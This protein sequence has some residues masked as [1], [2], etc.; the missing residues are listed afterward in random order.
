MSTHRPLFPILRSLS[1]GQLST[2]EDRPTLD[3]SVDLLRLFL[4]PSV[5]RVEMSFSPGVL[6]VSPVKKYAPFVTHLSLLSE[7][8]DYQ[9]DIGE[10]PAYEMWKTTLMRNLSA[11]EHLLSLAI[12]SLL[13]DS[14][15]SVLLGGIAS[16][17]SLTV[18]Y[19]CRG[20]SH[21]LLFGPESFPSL[22]CLLL[23]NVPAGEAISIIDQPELGRR[24]RVLNIS[25]RVA[26][27]SDVKEHLATILE[28]I[29]ERLPLVTKITLRPCIC[30]VAEYTSY[31]TTPGGRK[32]RRAPPMRFSNELVRQLMGL[33]SSLQYLEVACVPVAPRFL[34]EFAVAYPALRFLSLALDLGQSE[35]LDQP[36]VAVKAKGPLHIEA[37]SYY[38]PKSCGRSLVDTRQAAF[39]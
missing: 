30:E 22:T 27:L 38:P 4:S 16:L 28:R 3:P 5:T 1:L 23:E 20:V 2:G 37:Y 36:T 7:C 12:P 10:E 31:W 25:L 15:A 13:L 6:D 19:G 14:P 9:P 24:L 18:R 39:R 26:W 34:R 8:L 29:C 35:G 32:T 17:A 11:W 33:A 21:A